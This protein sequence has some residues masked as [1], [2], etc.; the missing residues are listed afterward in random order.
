MLTTHTI[1]G[2]SVNKNFIYKKHSEF[3]INCYQQLLENNIKC[4]SKLNDFKLKLYKKRIYSAI[5]LL[6]GKNLLGNI[7]FS[8][9]MM[10]ILYILF[11]FF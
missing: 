10:L 2:Y 5:I 6:L 7:Q 3:V 11:T 9:Y 8:L 4:E 1:P